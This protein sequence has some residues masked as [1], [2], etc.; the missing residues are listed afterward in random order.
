MTYVTSACLMMAQPQSTLHPTNCCDLTPTSQAPPTIALVWILAGIAVVAVLAIIVAGR[1]AEGVDGVAV[2]RIDEAGLWVGETLVEWSS[3]FE[4]TVVTRREF[5]GTWFG[6]E[7]RTESAGVIIV[8][9]GDGL[10]EQFLS[11]SHRFPGFDHVTLAAALQ[12]RRG[13]A[14]CYRA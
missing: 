13:R 7:L 1:N 9:R 12:R 6:F 4:I 3:I 10:G 2:D 5:G 11:N 8:E 14:V